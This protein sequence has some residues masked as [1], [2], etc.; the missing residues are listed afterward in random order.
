MGVTL[1]LLYVVYSKGRKMI[2]KDDNRIVSLS[3]GM[4]YEEIGKVYIWNETAKPLLEILEN[5]D[6]TFDLEKPNTFGFTAER[7]I[8]KRLTQVIKTFDENGEL[9]T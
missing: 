7:Y 5:G 8:H 9:T 4:D 1:Y 6:S 2:G 3:E